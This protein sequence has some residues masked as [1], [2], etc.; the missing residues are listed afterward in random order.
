MADDYKIH[1]VTPLD[2]I[3][4]PYNDNIDVEVAVH[5]VRYD[6]T[7]FTLNSIQTIFE[8]NCVSGECANGTYFWACDM[9][10]VTCITEDVIRTT[11]EGLLLDG[12]LSKAMAG[13]FP[14][15]LE[16]GWR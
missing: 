7:F 12:E 11:I 10:L 3:E 4:D 2:E 6:A 16:E 1:F 9:I 5:G 14:V 8:R 15:E 13:P